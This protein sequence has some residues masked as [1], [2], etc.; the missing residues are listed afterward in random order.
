MLFYSSSLFRT[1]SSEYTEVAR[2]EISDKGH[3]QLWF[4]GHK[5]GQYY[6]K[7]DETIWRCSRTNILSLDGGKKRCQ[8]KMKTKKIGGYEMIKNSNGVHDH[9]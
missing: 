6:Q 8:L 2:I 7:S 5:F 3:R 4:H 1:L 9:D